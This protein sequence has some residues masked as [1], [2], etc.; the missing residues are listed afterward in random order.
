MSNFISICEY[1]KVSPKEFYDNV[2]SNSML[3]GEI[4][5]AIKDMQDSYMELLRALIKRLK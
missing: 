4:I 5:D 2:N 3:Y 1:L